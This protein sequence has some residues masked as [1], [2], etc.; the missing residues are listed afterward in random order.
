MLADSLA[1]MLTGNREF[2][3]IDEQKLAFEKIMSVASRSNRDGKAVVIV[4]CGP[5]T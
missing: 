3:M 1:S 4:K 5:G 2:V